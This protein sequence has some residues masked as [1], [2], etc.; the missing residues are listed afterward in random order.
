VNDLVTKV[1]MAEPRYNKTKN[2]NVHNHSSY[3]DTFSTNLNTET[4]SSFYC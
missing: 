1:P 2:I 4:N 3:M